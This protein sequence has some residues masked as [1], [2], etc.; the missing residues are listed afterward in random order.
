MPSIPAFLLR[1][2]SVGFGL[3]TIFVAAI[4]LADPAGLSGLLLR[5]AEHPLPLVLLWGFFGMTFSAVQ[6]GAAVMLSA[7][8]APQGGRRVPVLVPVPVR[9][10]R[11]R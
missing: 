7:T 9:V 5:A 2:A 6:V 8:D 11:R 10:Q 1:Q 4:L 3:S